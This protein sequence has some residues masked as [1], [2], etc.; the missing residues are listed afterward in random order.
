MITVEEVLRG[1]GNSIGLTIK[2]SVREADYQLALGE[3]VTAAWQAAFSTDKEFHSG[4]V[5]ATTH[6]LL[7]C[8]CV[9]N[10]LIIASL[11]YAECIGIGDEHGRIL[12]VL[13]V[14]CGDV[15]IEIKA[16]GEHIGQIRDA[17]FKGIE[18]AP[19][20]KPLDFKPCLT[21]QS[22]AERRAIEKIK[23]GHK[24]ERRLSKS[25]AAAYGKCPSCTGNLLVEKRGKIICSKCGYEFKK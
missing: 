20:Q 8:S 13:P 7:C 4:I 1:K 12:K 10:N 19:L 18:A 24:D 21:L 23:F 9:A 3:R 5:A 15:H 17:I 11:P 14:H 25:E 22:S 2:D 6:R 16:S